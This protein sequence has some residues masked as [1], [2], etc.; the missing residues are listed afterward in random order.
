[1]KRFRTIVADPPWPF[2]DKLPGPGRGAAKHYA[3]MSI[4][5][6]CSLE[7]PP[8]EDDCTLLLWRVAS[9]QP[10]AVVVASSWGFTVKSEL[11]WC[12]VNAAGEPRIGMGRTVRNAHEVA[13][14]CTRGRPLFRD[15]SVPSWFTAPR[16]RH[17]EKPEA[18]YRL[19]ER[20]ADGPY[21]ELFGRRL[22]RGWT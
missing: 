12:K 15:R 13:L 5:E 20:L 14:I 18:F 11:V 22:R 21:V 9:M 19:V 8:L 17:S 16:G 3:C 6:L 2:E 7:L 10:E 4:E 1:M